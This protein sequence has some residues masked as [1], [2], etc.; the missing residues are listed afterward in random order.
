MVERALKAA[1]ELFEA[2][3]LSVEVIDLRSLS[4]LDRET[5]ISSVSKTGR[6]VIAEES[7]RTFGPAAELAAILVEGAFPYL[8]GPIYRACTADVPIPFSPP[9]E[10]EVLMDSQKLKETIRL[11]VGGKE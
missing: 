11:A 2:S 10:K 8:R 7:S 9:L 5:V 6:V 3:R 1:E 4:P